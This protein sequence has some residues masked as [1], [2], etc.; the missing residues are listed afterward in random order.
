M[1]RSLVL[2]ISN[3]FVSI[4][5][6]LINLFNS[7]AEGRIPPRTDDL[8]NLFRTLVASANYYVVLDALDE[9][10]SREDLLNFLA[11]FM[12]DK[13]LSLNV[14]VT[15]RKLREIDDF[16]HQYLTDESQISI[17]NDQ[18]DRDIGSFVQ[19]KLQ[20]DR[21]LRRWL[22]RPREQEEIKRR[23]MDKSAGM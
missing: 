9:C 3:S 17:Q 11:R 14:I 21:R 18:V 13:I 2:Q 7:C 15:S 23:L 5:D 1:L 16:F 20:H 19:G 6:P 12:T 10:E 8:E 22:D 4:P